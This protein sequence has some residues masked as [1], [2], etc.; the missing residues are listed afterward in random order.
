MK[1]VSLL[2][3]VITNLLVLNVNVFALSAKAPTTS[4]ILFTSVRDRNYEIYIMNTDGSKQVNLTKHPANDQQAVWSPTGEQILFVSDRDGVDDLYLMRPDGSNIRRVFKGDSKTSKGRPTWSPDGKQIAYSATDWNRSR[5]T[6]YIAT[7]GEE[8]E[9]EL[10][11]NATDPAWSPDGTGIACIIDER[12]TFVNLR[13]GERKHFLPKKAIQW[14]QLPSW[15]A[16]GDK[17]AFSGNNHPFPAIQDRQLRN[18]WMDK[19][20]IFIVNSDG[21]RFRQLV[22]EAGPPV[23]SPELSPDGQKALYTQAI[24]GAHQILKIDV[25]SGVQTQLTD[26][27]WNFGGDWFD[28]MYALQVS[29]QPYLLTTT[30]GRFRQ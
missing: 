17:L 3:C 20:T 19:N 18:E 2:V 12:L 11:I 1:T 26:N 10:V 25:H 28:P 30:W 23:W 6:I 22:D 29:P 24:N 4:K 16:A 9:D 13:G 14:Q 27:I 21:T 7:L 8:K 5:S 15:S